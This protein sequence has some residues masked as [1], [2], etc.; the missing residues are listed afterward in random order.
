MG[1]AERFVG[2]PWI[3]AGGLDVAELK[4]SATFADG[5]VSGSTG[6]NRFTGRYTLE[7]EALEIGQIASTRMACPPPADEVERAYLDALGRVA[8]W[9]FDGTDL[10]LVDGDGFELVRF[11]AASP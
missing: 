9:R 4:P 8:A 1:Q 10:V 2:V 3:V 11:R 7:G 5:T 6:C